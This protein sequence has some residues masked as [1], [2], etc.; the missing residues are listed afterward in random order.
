MYS[1][2]PKTLNQKACKAWE[3]MDFKVQYTQDLVIVLFVHINWQL[4]ILLFFF[5][6]T[7]IL[8]C[9][10]VFLLLFST[11]HHQQIVKSWY[12]YT[13]RLKLSLL[14]NKMECWLTFEFWANGMVRT[15]YRATIQHEI[16]HL[17]S[18]G[19][20]CHCDNFSSDA[21]CK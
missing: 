2:I 18:C 15:P 14:C 10:S 11:L 21:S 4:C 9:T 1:V 16:L 13:N 8:A 6:M 3:E 20:V 12:A 5:S 19:I 7:I 17:V